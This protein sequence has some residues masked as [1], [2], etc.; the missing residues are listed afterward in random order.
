LDLFKD[1]GFAFSPDGS[2]FGP[3]GGDIDKVDGIGEGAGEGIAAVGDG[4]GFEEAGLGLI[5]LVGLD[6]DLVA[7]EGSGFGGR[8]AS[9]FVV[10]ANW[11]EDAVDGGRRD[12]E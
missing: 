10:N 3:T 6:G 4:I 11:G 9:F 12:L 1:I 7:E 8:A 5:P 2:L